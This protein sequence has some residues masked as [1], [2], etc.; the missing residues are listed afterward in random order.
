MTKPIQGTQTEKNI[1]IAF[2]SESMAANRYTY[3][4]EASS[5]E[6][7]E[8]ITV[9]FMEAAEDERA[10]A[11]AFSKLFESGAVEIKATFPSV[12]VS[13]TKDNLEV[14]IAGEK[15]TWSQ[16]Y[17]DYARIAAEEG[18]PD[19]ANTFESIGGVEKLHEER[20]RKHLELLQG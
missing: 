19:I 5:R 8:Q 11:R 17:S 9:L 3:F 4:A 14:S 6:G 18:F 20:F 7:Y 15:A 1:M 10:H 13:K 2:A 12:V 16:R